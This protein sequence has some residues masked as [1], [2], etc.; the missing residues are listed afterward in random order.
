M[1]VKHNI[2]ENL[3]SSYLDIVQRVLNTFKPGEKPL[4]TNKNNNNVV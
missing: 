4:S 3:A 2:D 1:I